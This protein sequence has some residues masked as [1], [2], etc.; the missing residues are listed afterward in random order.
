MF[1]F[2]NWWFFNYDVLT[3]GCEKE[4]KG[5]PSQGGWIEKTGTGIQWDLMISTRALL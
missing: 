1:Y 5:T 3:L 2:K 4:G